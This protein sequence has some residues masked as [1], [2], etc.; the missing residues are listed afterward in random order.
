MFTSTYGASYYFSNS[1]GND[2]RSQTEAQ[3]PD[4]P[5]RSIDK[6]NLVIRNLQPGDVIYFR[7]GETFHGTINIS[8]AGSPG[9]PIRFSAYGSG[10]APIITS[11][12]SIKNWTSIGNG[13]FES[14]LPSLNSNEL[15]VVLMNNSV[16]E[17]GRYPNSDAPEKGY[18]T[19][20]STSGS[21]DITSQSLRSSP[22][23]KGAE[24]VIRKI[25]WI[26]DRHIITS[27][28]GNSILFADNPE[29]SYRPRPG[30]GF[31]IQNHIQ[32]LDKFGEWFFNKSSK[33]INVYFGNNQ[34][35]VNTVE[36]A[37][38]D[39]LVTNSTS[40]RD[41]IFENLHFKGANKDLFSFSSGNNLTIQNCVFEY[42]GE[43]GMTLTQM[44]D[45][46]MVDSRVSHVNNNGVDL[47]Y[48]QNFILRNNT[49]ENTFLFPGM[50]LS[51]DN[52]AM[53]I[54]A[55]GHNT[56]VE[57]NRILNS[58]YIGIR[59]GGDN[60]VVKDNYID[61]FC[62][63][64][65]DGGGIY[66]YS[67]RTTKNEGRKVINNII[68]NG[69][70]VREG[71]SNKNPVSKPQAE[72]IY[73][74]DN[75]T[76][77]EVSNNTIAHITSKGIYLHN[78]NGII[79]RNNTV[80]DSNHL[81]FLRNDLM[82]NPLT[83]NI[84]EHNNLLI[85][86]PFQNFVQIHTIYNDVKNLAVFNNN[87]YASPFFD[88][89]RIQVK[90]NAGSNDE[91]NQL[92]P[93]PAWQSSYGN[94][95]NSTIL[96]KKI[97][98]HEFI[99]TIGSLKSV[100]G[101]FD[102]NTNGYSCQNC[103]LSWDNSGILNGGS[104]KVDAKSNMQI[105]TSTGPLSRNKV[106]RVKFTAIGNKTH[107]ISLFL[108]H[109]GAPWHAVSATMNAEITNKKGEYEFFF[110]PRIN[111]ESSRLIISSQDPQNFQ[112]WL[113]DFEIQEVDV[114]EKSSQEYLLFKY[115]ENSKN[116]GLSLDGHYIDLTNKTVSGTLEVAPFSSVLL[117]KTSTGP[118]ETSQKPTVTLNISKSS[119]LVEG[120]NLQLTVTSNITNDLIS[121]V[122]YFQNGNS[123]GK[124]DTAPFS[125]EWSQLS[126]GSHSLS[127]KLTTKN[128][129]VANSEPI[130]LDVQQKLSDS[131]K[132]FSLF[133]NV[134]STKS[135]KISNV[136]FDGESNSNTFHSNSNTFEINN[137]EID[138]LFTTERFGTN[139]S[140]S[141]PVPDGK[142]V[143]RTLH[144]ELWYGKQGPTAAVGQRVFDI[145]IE[146][147][148]V[149]SNFDLFSENQN[150]PLV[151]IFNEVEVKDGVLNLNF[152][153]KTENPSISGIAI[154]HIENTLEPLIPL[155]YSTLHLLEGNLNLKPM[156]INTG[157]PANVTYQNETY[158]GDELSN[159]YTITRSYT[160]PNLMIEEL[161]KSERYAENLAYSI[162]IE[163][164]VYTVLTH[165]NELWYGHRGPA[166]VA[167]RRVFD[168][169][170]EQKIVKENFD[171]FVENASRPTT[172]KFENIV[173]SDGILN[174]DMSSSNDNATISGISII[175]QDKQNPLHTSE[176]A[177]TA[178]PVFINVGS[179]TG[180]NYQQVEF[181][182]DTQL[183][184]FDATSR[185][186]SNN[187]A[188]SNELFHS[189]R[190]DK[191]L[192]YRI[193]TPN[194]EYDVYTFHNELW[195][196][197]NGPTA[198]PGR[199]VFSIFV[200]NELVKKDFDLFIENGNRE[201][202]LKFTNIVV[203]DGV[204]NLELVAS[205]NNS[206]LSGIAIIPK[207][208]GA[209]YNLRTLQN[210]F[211]FEGVHED[212]WDIKNL[213]FNLYPNPASYR[214][215]LEISED[216]EIS[217]IGIYST[218]GQMVKMI[219]NSKGSERTRRLLIPI[220]DLKDGVYIIN[221][222]TANNGTKRMKLIVRQ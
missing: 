73:L 184:Y 30:Y 45:S 84:I 110:Q 171:I 23:W 191:N 194:G 93:L 59:F 137:Q 99:K 138:Q 149:K 164:G 76:G 71:T 114:N 113:D 121:N 4:T 82:G 176:S 125:L 95:R 141:I 183:E 97:N 3:N 202:T 54:F 50:G 219:Q 122:E 170:I 150:N 108:R 19:Y 16:Q 38:N 75:V 40:V 24:V 160:N 118:V 154:D 166:S 182:S 112:F 9:N 42:A 127:A 186:H 128:N 185:I 165:H 111:L 49:I 47:R 41:I 46:K 109:A 107:H 210:T 201:T 222:T 64:K 83:N 106:Y 20:E 177:F 217:G 179:L 6:L 163:N 103:S 85:D 69:E 86:D 155:K 48:S 52:R 92:F 180:T 129:E 72:G 193:P 220:E 207:G 57:N 212:R 55:G 147:K 81:I 209:G 17:M 161:F 189:E 7:R 100:N 146:G 1:I 31:F 158:S 65:N 208:G 34:P 61:R 2:S 43:S 51:G 66:A 89:C 162:P 148:I 133:L 205:A 157:S 33:K 134:G 145:I 96:S 168:I 181:S 197:K 80:Y 218:N 12:I 91:V 200:E 211:A 144:N 60:T 153:A 98:L 204:L 90:Y 37:T 63:T 117:V 5:W 44:A 126:A 70:G 151:L 199:R 39:Y 195:F 25:F 35:S 130:S 142:Y 11:L 28:S 213:D 136:T 131:A 104:M 79:V 21:N 214:T 94:D 53:G 116:S 196:G 159:Y 102:Q 88:D 216:I 14:S 188:S 68:L 169:W 67:N 124:T 198:A 175:P 174:I 101:T 58:G 22:N 190:F 74:D 13:I 192:R 115:N 132:G 221:I 119:G 156:Y 206:T 29:T 78:T 140:F 143:V 187:T 203:E 62:L 167:G 36:V 87:K 178:Q 27:H 172:L 32:T 215:V 120:E 18:L 152:G 123:L 10:N 8:K 135:A 77:V 56:L 105:N 173:I 26:T 15:M 139:M